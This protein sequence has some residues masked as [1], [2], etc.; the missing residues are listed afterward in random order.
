M[1]SHASN[2]AIS[3]F[4]RALKDIYGDNLAENT[5][6]LHDYLGMI[7][8]FLDRDNVKINMTKYRTKVIVDFP[9]EII[10]KAVMPAGNHLFKV[11][12]DG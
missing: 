10:G 1:I 11:R 6:K 7:F 8:D 2:E 4:L 9:E 5:G 3:Q 12:D